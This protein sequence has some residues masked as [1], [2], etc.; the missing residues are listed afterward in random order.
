MN[1]LKS[2]YTELISLNRY[3]P[4]LDSNERELFRGIFLTKKFNSIQ[5]NQ[6]KEILGVNRQRIINDQQIFV[7]N[8]LNS[9]Q[10]KNRANILLKNI[11]FKSSKFAKQN[12][13]IDDHIHKNALLEHICSSKLWIRRRQILAD[14]ALIY[15]LSEYIL[16]ECLS[17]K[18]QLF[19]QIS[20]IHETFYTLPYYITRTNDEKKRAEIR[21]NKI[22]TRKRTIQFHLHAT[23]QG[24]Q[25]HLTDLYEKL[26]ER[27]LMLYHVSKF[28]KFDIHH[29]V[30]KSVHGEMMMDAMLKSEFSQ[31]FFKHRP[32]DEVVRRISEKILIFLK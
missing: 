8:L 26:V 16:I 1:I 7:F 4:N 17:R 21:L 10:L 29:I 11:D 15:L 31:T 13:P 28:E 27:H 20:G 30:E 12:S 14:E 18:R 23:K 6:W 5:E 3:I 22:N 19:I 9:C 25:A 32:Q 2:R 24:Q